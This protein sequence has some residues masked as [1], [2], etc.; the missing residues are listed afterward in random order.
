VPEDQS[1]PHKFRPAG[2]INGPTPTGPT[3]SGGRN[4]KHPPVVRAPNG[5]VQD[6]TQEFRV[7]LQDDDDP[8]KITVPDLIVIGDGTATHA[9]LYGADDSS[10][11]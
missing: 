8:S 2:S 9:S 1:T 11:S 7:V 10:R 5:T 3:A 4:A 6:K